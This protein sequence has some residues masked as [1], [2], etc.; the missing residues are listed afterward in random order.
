MLATSTLRSYR[1]SSALASSLE[2][3][4][5]W[6][7]AARLQV[8]SARIRPHL[9]ISAAVSSKICVAHFCTR[10]L[11][12]TCAPAASTQC[13][14]GRQR[15]RISAAGIILDNYCRARVKHIWLSTS[16]DLHADAQ[17]DIADLGMHVKVINNCHD[18]DTAMRAGGL[19]KD[20]KEGVLFLTY[21]TL[22][23]AGR[24]RS[25]SGNRFQQVLDWVGGA[26]FDGCLVFDECHRCVS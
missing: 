18:L 3:V 11:H 14:L 6:A 20:Y 16:T 12:C 4:Q 26:S 21:S 23:S 17:R 8:C 10:C 15:A 2:T 13:T 24:G 5:A 22:V 7:K 25:G 9:V 19:C 1:P